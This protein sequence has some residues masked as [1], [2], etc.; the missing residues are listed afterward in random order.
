MPIL[1]KQK[2]QDDKL[3]NI[4][5]QVQAPDLINYLIKIYLMI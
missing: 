2:G 3:E 4:E 5:L 1:P